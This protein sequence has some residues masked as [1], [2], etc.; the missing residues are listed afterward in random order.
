MTHEEEKEFRLKIADEIRLLMCSPPQFDM[1]GLDAKGMWVSIIGYVAN[2]VS[3]IRESD[4]EN[5]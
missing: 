1:F 5:K 3:G 2:R 4:E